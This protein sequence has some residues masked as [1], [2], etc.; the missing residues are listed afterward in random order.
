M[1]TAAGKGRTYSAPSA[2]Q[3]GKSV[4]IAAEGA[5]NRL[6]FYWTANGSSTWTREVVA[7]AGTTTDAPAV[8][9]TVNNGSVNVAAVNANTVTTMSYWA[10]NGT[11]TWH[12]ERL[13]GFTAGA[14]AITTYPGGVHVVDRD[15]F[16]QLADKSGGP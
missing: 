4:I 16:G 14:P 12:P 9:V 15:W 1:E 8:T 6:D 11:T 5:G 3:D 7:G 13:P 2:V 10:L